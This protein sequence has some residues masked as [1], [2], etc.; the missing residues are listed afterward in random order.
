MDK[1]ISNFSVIS[2]ATK[3]PEGMD[4]IRL[5]IKSE[6]ESAIYNGLKLA[7]TNWLY[8]LFYKEEEQEEKINEN[9]V[10]YLEANKIP[11][12]L[13]FED[14]DELKFEIIERLPESEERDR[15]LSLCYDTESDNSLLTIGFMNQFLAKKTKEFIDILQEDKK[16]T[17]TEYASLIAQRFYLFDKYY[18]PW[19]YNAKPRL[20]ALADNPKTFTEMFIA[21]TISKMDILLEKDKVI[22]AQLFALDAQ[23]TINKLALVVDEKEQKTCEK[24]N[25]ALED[26]GEHYCDFNYKPIYKVMLKK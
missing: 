6:L 17:P 22:E 1:N 23:R 21:T 16:S 4:Q 26:L 5:L 14:P 10:K 9:I 8:S 7:T 3:I 24:A 18:I 11:I 13:C 2:G 19:E 15:L 20:E 25:N 12:I